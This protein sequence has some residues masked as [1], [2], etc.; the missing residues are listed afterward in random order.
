MVNDID[1]TAGGFLRATDIIG[2]RRRGI[3][4]LFPVSRSTWW[5]GVRDGRYP[6]P[7]RLS[8]GVTAWRTADIRKLL[9]DI[10]ASAG[11]TE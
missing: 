1:L 6:Q 8:P 3:R 11:D 7:V 5:A 10:E 2:D 4:G 9:A